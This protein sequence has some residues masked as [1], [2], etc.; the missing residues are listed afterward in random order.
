[1][2]N[3]YALGA[4]TCPS[5]KSLIW[6]YWTGKTWANA[7]KGLTIVTSYE[8]IGKYCWNACEQIQGSCSWCG[9]LG[10]CCK[11]G[12]RGNG[13]DGNLGIAKKEHSCVPSV[14]GHTGKGGN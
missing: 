5:E 13:C 2:T 10:M 3:A 9:T 6:K 8:N 4:T 14:P 11:K 12:Y 1:M 7:G